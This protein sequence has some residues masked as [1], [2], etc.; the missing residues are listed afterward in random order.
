MKWHDR[1]GAWAARLKNEYEPVE[2]SIAF[3]FL[4]H[5]NLT[6]F[7]KRRAK[8]GEMAVVWEF[9]EWARRQGKR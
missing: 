5:A 7:V 4:K 6:R 1:K 3:P 9:V 2:R 8:L